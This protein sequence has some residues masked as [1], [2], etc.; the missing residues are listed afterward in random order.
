[1]C[2]TMLDPTLPLTTL[3]YEEF[4]DPRIETEFGIIRSYSPYDNIPVGVCHPPMLIMASFNDSRVGVWE[5][6]KWVARV[7]DNSCLTCSQMII[8]RTNMT[9]GHFL[10]GGRF[11]QCEDAAE[12]YAFLIK[13]VGM[14]D[15]EDQS[16]FK[17]ARCK[18]VIM[19]MG[20]HLSKNLPHMSTKQSRKAGLQL[21]NMAKAFELRKSSLI[22]K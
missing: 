10:E 18:P 16:E 7:R 20:L 5:A 21:V 11:K 2:N 8:L 19:A 17:E 3:D 4:G 22:R 9:G 13:A 14:L 1:M 15:D 6:A 12:E